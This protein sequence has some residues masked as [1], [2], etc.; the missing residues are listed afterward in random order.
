[1]G[2]VGDADAFEDHDLVV[3]AVAVAVA[4]A[5]FSS[6]PLLCTV[7]LRPLEMEG[8]CTTI[9]LVTPSSVPW[10]ASMGAGPGRSGSVAGPVEPARVAGSRSSA[11]NCPSSVESATPLP[12][13]VCVHEL[14][15]AVCCVTRLADYA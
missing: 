8:R 11:P 12:T 1:M 10:A 6:R 3:V 14:E 7:P 15:R 9:A 4:V 5:G 13:S 2:G